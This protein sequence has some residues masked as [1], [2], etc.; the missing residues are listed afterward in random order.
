MSS[1]NASPKKRRAKKVKVVP[2]PIEKT[3]EEIEVEERP[4][5]KRKPTALRP[6]LPPKQVFT[7][8]QK[9]WSI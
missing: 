4:K 9:N 6:T 5:V 7:E 8:R 3:P 1:S 2:P